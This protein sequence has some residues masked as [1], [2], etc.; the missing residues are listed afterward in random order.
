MGEGDH[1][2]GGVPIPLELSEFRGEG[3][4]G[5]LPSKVRG[6]ELEERGGDCGRP[7][8]CNINER[9]GGS[10]VIAALLALSRGCCCS[11]SLRAFVAGVSV[12]V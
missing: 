12:K 4:D 8:L 2:L 11:D 9:H 1:S 7:M 10:T 5:A 6:G 3:A